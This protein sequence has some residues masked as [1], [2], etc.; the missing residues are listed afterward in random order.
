MKLKTL[1]S[2]IFDPK[3]AQ[4]RVM[5]TFSPPR[6]TLQGIKCVSI[7]EE[8]HKNYY[9]DGKDQH[10]LMQCWRRERGKKKKRKKKEIFLDSVPEE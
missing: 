5:S 2:S 10:L 8:L 3:A 7:T 6:H 9:V 1:M 4:D